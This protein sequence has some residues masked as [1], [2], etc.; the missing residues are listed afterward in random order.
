MMH[1]VLYVKQH[2]M[3]WMSA[4][5]AGQPSI[6]GARTCDG[7][8]LLQPSAGLC[9]HWTQMSETRCKSPALGGRGEGGKG[10]TPAKL[11]TSAQ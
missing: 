1:A 5:Q 6:N 4:V 9:M 7:C 8:L 2:G 3:H 10:L 11:K